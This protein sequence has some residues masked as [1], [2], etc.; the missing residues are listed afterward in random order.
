MTKD[1][2]NKN[3]SSDKTKKPSR[4]GRK[5]RFQNVV[6]TDLSRVNKLD[7]ILGR[8]VMD[9]DQA[10]GQQ[11][12]DAAHN[13]D[14]QRMDELRQEGAPINYQNPINKRTAIHS[15]A[16]VGHEELVNKIL[17][18]EWK[19]PVNLLLRDKDGLLPSSCAGRGT[20]GGNI[21]AFSY[22]LKKLEQAQ[23][24]ERDPPIQPRMDG[25]VIITSDDHDD[26]GDGPI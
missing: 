7:E 12:L 18:S 9:Q 25:D 3:G 20:G 11:L 8:E 15:L 16:F 1:S 26:L 24:L 23:G 4:L 19:D 17:D 22:R 21:A 5:V 6:D 2:D 10:L 13:W 14:W